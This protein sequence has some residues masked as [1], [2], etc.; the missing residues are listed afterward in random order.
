MYNLNKN[1]KIE[2]IKK[3]IEDISEVYELTMA[4][5]NSG[6]SISE[7]TINDRDDLTFLVMDLKSNV[8]KLE[9]FLNEIRFTIP[10]ELRKNEHGVECIRF[11]E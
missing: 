9:S 3:L 4:K 2:E 6:V 5:I 8:E 7:L 1:E 10:Y 11:L